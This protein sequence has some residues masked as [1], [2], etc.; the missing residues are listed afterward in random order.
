MDDGKGYEMSKM[1]GSSFDDFLNEEGI[2]EEVNAK[3]LQLL[4]LWVRI[5]QLQ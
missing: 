5:S 4:V 2:L 1:I 3:A